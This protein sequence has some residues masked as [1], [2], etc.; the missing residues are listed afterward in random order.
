MEG[1]LEL[2]LILNYIKKCVD[3]FKEMIIIIPVAS[4]TGLWANSSVGR[5]TPF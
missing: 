3:L 1:E 5:A 2:E 4:V